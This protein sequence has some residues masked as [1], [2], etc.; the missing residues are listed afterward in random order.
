MRSCPAS[1]AKQARHA[2]RPTPS[3]ALR[4]TG[5][6]RGGDSRSCRMAAEQPLTTHPAAL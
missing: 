6:E 5:T 2:L 1:P 3:H 4:A